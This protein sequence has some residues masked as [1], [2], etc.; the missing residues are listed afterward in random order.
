MRVSYLKACYRDPGKD[1][2]VIVQWDKKERRDLSSSSD[3]L[4][5]CGG[6]LEQPWRR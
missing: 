3:L 4:N 2:G 6:W 5:C 1:C